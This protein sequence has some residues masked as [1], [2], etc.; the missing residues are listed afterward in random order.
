[1]NKVTLLDLPVWLGWCYCTSSGMPVHMVYWKSCRPTGL[2]LYT[3]E[4]FSCC[5]WR[6]LFTSYLMVRAKVWLP[7]DRKQRLVILSL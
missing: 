4:G 1:M 2:L 6:L 7:L 5:I 3:M